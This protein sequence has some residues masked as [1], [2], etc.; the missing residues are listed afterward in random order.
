[1]TESGNP[2]TDLAYALITS[3]QTTTGVANI[4]LNYAKSV[5]KSTLG[6]AS[7][8]DPATR[9]NVCLTLTGM[10][11]DSCHM[12]PGTTGIEFPLTDSGEY[13]SLWGHALNT[14]EAFYDNNPAGHP[15][16]VGLPADHVSVERFLSVPVMYGDDLLGQ[17]SLANAPH[18]YRDEDLAAVN[19]IAGLYSHAL[20]RFSHPAPAVP[21][22]RSD[23]PPA[24]SGESGQGGGDVQALMVNLRRIAMPYVEQLKQTELT[25]AQHFLLSKI[26]EALEG[27]SPAFLG[28]TRIMSVSFT[29]QE[30]QV[31]V[32]IKAG[33]KTK[34]IAD[35]L[36][37]SINAVNF[38][39]KN[40]R[41]K[42]SI[43]NKQVSLQTYLASLEEW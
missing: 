25:D 8:I 5:T 38:H 21:S 26:Q 12:P 31:A 29:P 28:N 34:D 35:E 11:G 18:E 9:K 4:V 10:I 20:L 1:M 37:I 40:I 24:R 3:G 22:T 43:N 17:I 13:P 41:K 2:I 33:Q 19:E 23:E 39:R 7:V 32:L 14:R 15:A 16:S 27:T 6:Y 30:L 36:D 42:L